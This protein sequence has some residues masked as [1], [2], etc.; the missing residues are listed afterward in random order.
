MSK[1]VKKAVQNR[2]D[3]TVLTNPINYDVKNLIFDPAD[4]CTIPNTTIG[5]YRINI[6]TKNS[7]GKEGEL[8]LGFDRC[9]SSGLSE[10]R[11]QSSNKLTGYS[12]ALT[13]TNRDGSATEKQQATLNVI[14]SII[15]KA[16]EHL[17]KDEV[18]EEVERYFKPHELENM[19]PVWLK[20]EKGKV[21]EGAIPMIFC[22]L[23][24]S[25][26]KLD[27]QGKNIPAK[28]VTEFLLEGT[29]EEVNALD[30]LGKRCSVRAAVKVESIF[31]N[32][33]DVKLQLKLYQAAV[34]PI[35]TGRKRLLD[36][37]E[38]S[39]NLDGTSQ[40]DMNDDIDLNIE[41]KNNYNIYEEK[42]ELEDEV[43]IPQETEKKTKGKKK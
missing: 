26:E 3:N 39:I 41:N 19:S 21:V 4:K 40:F 30:F 32:K 14:E 43:I 7:N 13:L 12:L 25:K 27:K 42:I 31:V 38:T 35:E 28:I 9:N 23:L 1:T 18:Q 29:G 37:E 20:K 11:D 6:A 8:V 24:Y 2:S 22:K 34:K 10:V 16:R 17:M 15:E 5:Y 36:M 33:K